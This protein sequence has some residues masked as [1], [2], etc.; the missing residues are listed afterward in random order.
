MPVFL[1]FRNRWYLFPH[2]FHGLYGAQG[3]GSG[4]G[5]V[6][7][8]RLAWICAMDA[9]WKISIECGARFCEVIPA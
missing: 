8:A 7:V 4:T 9:W 2:Q 5:Q 1:L 3:F 6:L